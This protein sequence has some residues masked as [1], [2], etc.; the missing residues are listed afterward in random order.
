MNNGALTLYFTARTK[1]LNFLYRVIP[2]IDEKRRFPRG[3]VGGRR[4]FPFF[5]ILTRLEKK[6]GDRIVERE[7]L[8]L[9][10]YCRI[11]MK[12][13]IRSMKKVVCS[14]RNSIDQKFLE[15]ECDS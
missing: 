15:I 1:T 12:K 4:F 8:V 5:T 6:L 2:K 3:L 13:N 7:I 11:K 14:H 10:E 9:E